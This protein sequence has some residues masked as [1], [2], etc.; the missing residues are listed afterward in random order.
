MI[1]IEMSQ[2]IH[3]LVLFLFLQMLVDTNIGINP[4]MVDLSLKMNSHTW[5]YTYDIWIEQFSYELCH[6]SWKYHTNL[7]RRNLSIIENAYLYL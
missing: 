1:D 2:Y 6:L 3:I 4:R 5:Y 7:F